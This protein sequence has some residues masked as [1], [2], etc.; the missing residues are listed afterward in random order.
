LN[1]APKSTMLLN[2]SGLIL[3]PAAFSNTTTLLQLAQNL[4]FKTL[5]RDY[6]SLLQIIYN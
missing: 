6:F 5:S 3:V 1:Y 4:K 2:R